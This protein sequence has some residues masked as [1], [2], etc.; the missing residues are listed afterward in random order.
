MLE[1]KFSKKNTQADITLYSKMVVAKKLL[2]KDESLRQELATLMA[3]KCEGR[4]LWIKLQQ[5]QLR[6]RKSKKELR[7]I[8]KSM[9]NGLDQSY[10]RKWTSITNLS[11][12]DR[13]RAISILL[14]TTFALRPL[15][16]DELAEALI[17]EPDIYSAYLSGDDLPEDINHEYINGE[18]KNPCGSLIEIRSAAP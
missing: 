16:I 10:G 12:T 17:V 1:C 5:E 14:L 18:K 4:F 9:P 3:E 2:R 8:V 7:N 11:E 6:G 15:T 13:H